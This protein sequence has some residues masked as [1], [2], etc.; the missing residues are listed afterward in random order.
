MSFTAT[1]P[2]LTASGKA[3]ARNLRWIRTKMNQGYTI[4]DI[5]PD[6]SRADPTARSTAW[7]APRHPAAAIRPFP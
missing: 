4:A 3:M 6:F 7:R 1:A 5:G 2:V